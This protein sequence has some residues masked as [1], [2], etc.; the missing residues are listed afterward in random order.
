MNRANQCGGRTGGSSCTVPSAFEAAGKQG[1]GSFP[2]RLSV[3]SE[4]RRACNDRVEMA[5][6]TR[7]PS[8]TTGRAVFSHPAV[9]SNGF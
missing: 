3:E 9:E 4:G 8:H 7:H 2:K 5:G 6:V 1:R